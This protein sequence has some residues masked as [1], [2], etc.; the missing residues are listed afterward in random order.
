VAPVRDEVRASWARCAPGLPVGTAAPVED[1]E[2]GDRWEESPIRRLAPDVTTD[3]RRVA[4]DG[5][6]V[7][8]IT[9]HTGQI[10]WSWGGRSMSKRAEQVNFITGGRWDERSA[11]T[12]APGLALI[13]GAPATVFAG[14]HW[15]ESV[16]DWV[17]YAA[18]VRAADGSPLGVID[19]STTWRRAT[20]LA[21]TTVTAIARLLEVQLRDQ[22]TLHPDRAPVLSLQALGHPRASLDG[23][24]LLL[25]LRQFEILAILVARERATLDEL[26]ALLYGDR[27]VSPVTLKAEISHLRRALAGGISSRPYRLDVDHEADFVVVLD[28]LRTGDTAEAARRYRGQ[29]LPASEAPFIVDQRHHLDVAVRAAVLRW[30]SAADL[31]R[32]AEVHPYDLEVLERAGQRA[33]PEN[34]LL[35]DIEARLDAARRDDLGDEDPQH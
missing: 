2:V 33:A 16:H 18:P 31:L 30:G 9:D 34:P 8:A 19:L 35:A 28:R 13:T 10:L 20:P 32:F 29:L 3:L 21:L 1:S 23:T 27:P 24:V 6:F 7:A 12:N 22:A 11:G 5:D 26:H 25:P 15:C 17:C 4:E 14:E